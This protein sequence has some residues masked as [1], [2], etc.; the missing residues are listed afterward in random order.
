MDLIIAPVEHDVI[1]HELACYETVHIFEQGT[2]V[3]SNDS[4]GWPFT[5]R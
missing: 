3:K 2:S 4:N 5:I 1:G